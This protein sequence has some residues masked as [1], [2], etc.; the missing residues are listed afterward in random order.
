MNERELKKLIAVFDELVEEVKNESKEESRAAL[1]RMG[2]VDE[3]GNLTKEYG[4]LSFNVQQ[5]A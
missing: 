5:T 2:I 3:A 4:G 1:V